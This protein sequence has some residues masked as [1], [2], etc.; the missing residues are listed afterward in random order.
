MQRFE[1]EGATPSGSSPAEFAAFFRSEA[2][3]WA[4]VAKRSGT[5]LD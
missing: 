4:E 2:E 5:R 3:K 1:A